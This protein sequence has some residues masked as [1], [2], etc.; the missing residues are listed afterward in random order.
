MQ[1]MPQFSG[2]Q[3]SLVCK[4]PSE[5]LKKSLRSASFKKIFLQE[6]AI[7]VGGFVHTAGPLVF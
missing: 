6:T 5:S 2:P 7:G 1:S 3:Q 4:F